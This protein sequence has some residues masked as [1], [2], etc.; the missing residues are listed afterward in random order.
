[1]KIGIITFTDGRE[2]VAKATRESCLSFQG[3]IDNWLTKQKHKV[4]GVK[5]PVWNW[6]TAAKAAEQVNRAGVDVC[7]F[8]FCVWS[9]PDLTAQ[10]AVRLGCPILFIGNINPSYPGW[11]AFFASAGTMKELGIPFGRVLGDISEKKVQDQVNRWLGEHAPEVRMRGEEVAYK[12]HGMRY[13]EFDGP[14]MGMYTGH[15]DQSQWME[16]LGVHVYHRGQLHL[17][18]MARQIK[19]DRVAA[20]LAW[21]E[22]HCKAI[23]YNNTHLTPGLDGTLAR[24]VRMYL[25]MKDFCREEGLDFCGLSGQLDMT[26]WDELCIGDVQEAILNDTADWEENEKKPLICATECDSNAALTMQVLHLLTGTPVLFAD[27]RHYHADLDLYDL[28][29]SGQHAP[30]FAKRSKNFRLNWKEVTLYPPDTFYFR[31][32]GASVHF[33]AAP[34]KEVTYARIIRDR[35]RFV[36]HAFTG[37]FVEFSFEKSEKLGKQTSYTW[38]HV[39]AKFDISVDTLAQHF[40]AN[41][42][43]AVVGNCLGELQAF[44]EAV[45]IDCVVLRK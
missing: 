9:Y 17:W 4:T 11:V 1:M 14:S 16:Q 5:T 27:L 8:N 28:V 13:G 22:K 34:A 42:I 23:K 6:E 2:R 26:E 31:G 12:L 21:L 29:N 44:C 37:S 36:M 15:V 45:D 24:Q 33:Y 40:S 38:P 39:W 18:Q 32:G 7:I 41:H 43:H 10:V 3:K 35:G 20:G 30:W 19:K 25:A